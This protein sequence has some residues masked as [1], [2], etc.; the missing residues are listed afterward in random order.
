MEFG[1]RQNAAQRLQSRALMGSCILFAASAMPLDAAASQIETDDPD[2][3]MRWD[4]TVKY[5][6][7]FRLR[8]RSERIMSDARTDDG[9]RNFGKGLISN[10][11][12]LF[13]EFDLS[14]RNFGGR[15]S[16]AGWYDSVYH[17]S[18]DNNSPWTR[19]TNG[20]PSNEFSRETRRRMGGKLELFDAFVFG[21]GEIGGLA[22]TVRAGRHSV[23]FGETLF[24]GANGIANA[25]GPIDLVKL[26]AVPGTQFKEV[27]RPVPQIS[28]QLQLGSGLSLSAYYQFGWAKTILPPAGSY[29]STL[30]LV[31]EGA[32]SALP[33][34]IF[35]RGPDLKPKNSGQWGMQLRYRIESLDADLGLYAARYHDKTPQLYLTLDPAFTPSHLVHA[36]AQGIKTYGASL[37]KTVGEA[38]ISAEVSVRRGAPLVTDPQTILPTAPKDNVAH[39]AYAIG[40]TLHANLSMVYNVP[41]SPLWD[42]GFLLGEL[43]WNRTLSVRANAAALD[44]NTTRSALALRLLFLPTYYQVLPG[45]D[46]TIPIGLGY[47]PK[48]K[49]SAVFAFNGGVQR[50]GDVSI[51][52]TGNYRNT[53]EF[54]IN[55][56]HYLGRADSFL[57]PP[58]SQTAVLSYG[59]ALKD[60][61][62][63][64][65]NVKRTF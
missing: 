18:N 54:G 2:L 8:E 9:D 46:L 30:D 50:G 45:L 17:G 33:G 36:Y 5:S 43:A 57:T 27:L 13:S 41:K 16:A 15:I 14:Y 59:Q 64:S 40:N 24:F 44:P 63:V 31:G 4:N 61:N 52:I 47:V 49:S 32:E 58:N 39:P 10:R 25:Q 35:P 29:L 11:V 23:I 12:D 42:S 60:R 37:S 22:G 65:F 3:K 20:L 51:G 19:N 6:N 55:Y 1:T 48:G 38:N 34:G 26:L 56:V 62:F 53:W 7:A 21:K 28:G